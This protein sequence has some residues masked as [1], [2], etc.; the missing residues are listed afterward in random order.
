MDRCLEDTGPATADGS[1]LQVSEYLHQEAAGPLRKV[2]AC[3]GG[4]ADFPRDR[5]S[6]ACQILQLSTQLQESG[7]V[8]SH[9]PISFREMG[10]FVLFCFKFDP[11]TN[12]RIMSYQLT[13]LMLEEHTI[14]F[15]KGHFTC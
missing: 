7:T 4:G 12:R 13:L 10:F 14:L 1:I 5:D 3:L 8:N 9:P 6:S 15:G 2:K 11:V